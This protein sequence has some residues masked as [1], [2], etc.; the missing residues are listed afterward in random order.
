MGTK[1]ALTIDHQSYL[2]LTDRGL[3]SS[4]SL[5]SVPDAS[6]FLPFALIIVHFFPFSRIRTSFVKGKDNNNKAK[7]ENKTW[8]QIP[9]AGIRLE[10][11]VYPYNMKR[12]PCLINFKRTN[13]KK[14]D[15]WFG[16]F[17]IKQNKEGTKWVCCFKL[18]KARILFPLPLFNLNKTHRAFRSFASLT[19]YT[20]HYMNVAKCVYF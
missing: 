15:A 16:A 18:N 6:L 19:H 20:Y 4:S 13:T 12:V 11:A 8:R 3:T 14:N 2:W 7:E 5:T 1:S 17:E 9:L 10:A